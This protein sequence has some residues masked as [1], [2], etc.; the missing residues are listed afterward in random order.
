MVLN[1]LTYKGSIECLYRRNLE[2]EFSQMKGRKTA[3]Q[4]GDIEEK[5]NSLL[6][7]IQRWRQVQ[8]VYM[9]CVGALLAS[10]LTTTDYHPEPAESTPLHLPSSLPPDLHSPA[11]LVM[12]EKECRLRVA[13]ADDALAEIRRQRRII[14]S[15]WQFK[16]LNVDGTGNKPQTRMRTLYNRFNLRT[17][18]CAARYC[19]ARNVL[20]AHNPEGEWKGRL[21]ELKNE[22]IRGPGKEDDGSSNSRFVPSWIWLVPGVHSVSDMGDS[23]IVLDDS[24]RVE[25]AKSQ[26]RRDRWEEEFLIVQEEMRRVL[27]YHEWRAKWWRTRA[28]LRKGLV[29]EDIFHG[30]VAYAEKQAHVCEQLARRC[31]IYW[32]PILHVKGITPAWAASYPLPVAAE[33]PRSMLVDESGFDSG[34]ITL[35]AGRDDDDGEEID[36]EDILDGGDLNL[37]IDRFELDE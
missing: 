25:W 35:E 29:H 4:L 22:D 23:N 21:Q 36:D 27:S 13:Q 11:M 15:L 17:Q 10:M 26:A 3:K 33:V 18:R 8:L 7:R 32:L 30:V 31:A 24:M 14:S 12:I 20:L 2:L 9:P 1:I 19:K 34:S 5:R 37:G 28:Q 16:K 6:N